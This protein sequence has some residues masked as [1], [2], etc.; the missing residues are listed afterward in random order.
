[1]TRLR[2]DYAGQADLYDLARPIR[3]AA[4]VEIERLTGG[5][6]FCP[7][8]RDANILGVQLSA[9]LLAYVSGRVNGPGVVAGNGLQGVLAAA[10][11]TLIANAAMGFRP[12]I[13]GKPVPPSMNAHFMLEQ[14]CA[15]TMQQIAI[16]EQGLHD[17]VVPFQRSATGGLEVKPFDYT[18]MLKGKP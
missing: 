5:A 11:G 9:V 4:L 12:M 3:D 1:M 14:I 17:F 6:D 16:N 8:A 7:H 13:E 18:D 10:I 2:Q 15:H